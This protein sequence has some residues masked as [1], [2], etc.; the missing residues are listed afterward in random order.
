MP[1]GIDGLLIDDDLIRRHPRQEHMARPEI[2]SVQIP[3]ATASVRSTCAFGSLATVQHVHLNEP[4]PCHGWFTSGR[5][6]T[7]DIMRETHTGND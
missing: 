2:R 5:F 6:D 1:C 3:E 4:Q 7:F